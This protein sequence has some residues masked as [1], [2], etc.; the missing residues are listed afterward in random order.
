MPRCGQAR[1][2]CDCPQQV[3]ALRWCR[4]CEVHN[5]APV[6]LSRLFVGPHS[7]ARARARAALAGGW[8]GTGKATVPPG[9]SAAVAAAFWDSV[10]SMSMFVSARLE[11]SRRSWEEPMAI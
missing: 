9:R 5:L 8:G 4:A 11:T 2:P 6:A 1:A 10:L 3:T 7:L